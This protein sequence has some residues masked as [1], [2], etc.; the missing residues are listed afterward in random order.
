MAEPYFQMLSEQI[1]SLDLPAAD[2]V[3]LERRHF[4]SGAALYADGKIC[5]SLTPAGFG[6]KLPPEVRARLLSEGAG[7]EL[8]YFEKAPVKKD[9]VALSE[10][11]VKDPDALRPLVELSIAYVLQRPG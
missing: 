6:L 10:S 7:T 8:R 1:A 11:T 9:Y 5:A 4:F 2:H 3:L